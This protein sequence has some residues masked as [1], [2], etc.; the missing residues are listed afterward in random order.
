MKTYFIGDTHF[1]HNNVLKYDNRPY[2]SIE[3]HD[4][5][6]IKLWNK[7]VQNGDIVYLMGDLSLTHSSEK[8]IGYISKL[9]GRKRLVMGNHDSRNYEWYLNNGFER[10]YDKPVILKGK[11]VLSHEPIDKIINDENSP[12]F[13][14]YAHVHN[15][16]EYATET[17][18]SL[19]VSCCRWN[20]KP[21][22]I[23]LYDNYNI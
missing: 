19:C 12:F 4:K 1:G 9:K 23:E 16:P 6:L 13:N 21:I 11:F 15:H 7:T 14:I 8:L 2:E 5:A 22:T 10:V 3:E 18:T 17:K 20:Y